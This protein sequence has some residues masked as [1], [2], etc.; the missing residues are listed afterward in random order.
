MVRFFKEFGFIFQSLFLT[1]EVLVIIYLILYCKKNYKEFTLN[2]LGISQSFISSCGL[3][4]G[5]IM[6]II[7]LLL[8]SFK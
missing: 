2:D 3:L 7:Y 4:M 1:I 5:L 8:T 6:D